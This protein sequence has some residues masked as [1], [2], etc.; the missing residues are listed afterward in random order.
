MTTR[1]PSGVGSVGAALA[2]VADQI[3]E[4]LSALKTLSD[5]V[6]GAA[7][8]EFIN[9]TYVMTGGTTCVLTTPTAAALV[10]AL[11]N[12]QVGSVFETQI[13]NLNSGNC[14]VT[15]GD[16]VT[17]VNNPVLSGADTVAGAGSGQLYTGVVTAVDTPAVTMVGLLKTPS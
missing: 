4:R 3:H 7:A 1:F 14:T 11:T 5:T 15:G 10:A 9:G 8:E 16:G 17:M 13:R 12:A 2:N 6:V